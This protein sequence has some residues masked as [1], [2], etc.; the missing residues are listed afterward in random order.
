[1]AEQPDITH[2]KNPWHCIALG[3]GSGLAPRMPGTIGTLCCMLSIYGIA[4]VT[5]ATQLS[6]STY[7]AGLLV[8][9]LIGVLSIN[10]YAKIIGDDDNSHIVIDEFAGYWV[11][12]YGI[13]LNWQWMLAAFILFR[14]FDIVKPFP[15]NWCDS[16][17]K[18]SWGIMLDDLIAGFYS[19][20]IVTILHS[21]L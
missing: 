3:F 21:N 4:Q 14:F 8:M 20:I 10:Q 16:H 17:I 12:L 1:M 15:I 5:G 2:L 9:V 19:L 18:G 11:T 6:T 13:S 7:L